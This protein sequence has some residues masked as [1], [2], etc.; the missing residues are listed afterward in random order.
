MREALGPLIDAWADA[1]KRTVRRTVVGDVASEQGISP[2]ASQRRGNRLRDRIESDGDA[3]RL[4]ASTGIGG[5]TDRR[6]YRHSR[7]TEAADGDRRFAC[8]ARS[9][10]ALQKV[11]APDR[12]SFVSGGSN[13]GGDAGGNDGVDS[14]AAGE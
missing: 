3:R 2:H 7:P 12:R 1:V 5:L 10:S 14:L 11:T 4:V 13:L 9:S 6:S 8:K